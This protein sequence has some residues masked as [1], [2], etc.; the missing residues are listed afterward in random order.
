MPAC[1]RRRIM[2]V[3]GSKVVA[4][5]PDWLAAFELHLGDTVE[6]IYDSVVLIKPQEMRID[7]DFLCKELAILREKLPIHR[8]MR[9]C[10]RRTYQ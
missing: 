7:P 4:M 9:T 6:V 2:A 10:N 5:P 8:K 1:S 3:G